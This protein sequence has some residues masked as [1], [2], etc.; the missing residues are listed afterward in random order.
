[1]GFL[2]PILPL[3]YFRESPLGNFFDAEADAEADAAARRRG[4]VGLPGA[5]GMLEDGQ[6]D[7]L[8]ADQ[9][10]RTAVAAATAAVRPELTVSTVFHTRVQVS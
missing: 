5:G 3:F 10:T 1:M 9:R 6:G 2:Y 7:G 4:P 8:G